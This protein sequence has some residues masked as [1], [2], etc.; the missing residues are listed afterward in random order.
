MPFVVP[1][2]LTPPPCLLSFGL[3]AAALLPLVGVVFY[4]GALSISASLMLTLSRYRSF[5]HSELRNIFFIFTH[6]HSYCYTSCHRSSPVTAP[7][8][9]PHIS[10]SGVM[11][12]TVV[13]LWYYNTELSYFILSLALLRRMPHSQRIHWAVSHPGALAFNAATGGQNLSSQTGWRCATNGA[14]F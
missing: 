12:P 9:P 5:S 6:S 7:H 1:F 14:N 11:V 8:P 2:A 3:A 10:L 13:Q 4:H